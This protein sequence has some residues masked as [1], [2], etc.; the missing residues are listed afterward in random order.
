MKFMLVAIAFSADDTGEASFALDVNLTLED[1]TLL[2]ADAEEFFNANMVG[3]VIFV[4][5]EDIFG[6]E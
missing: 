5:E 3:E 1:C 2:R 6:E 4:C